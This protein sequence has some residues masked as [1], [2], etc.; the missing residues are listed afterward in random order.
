MSECLFCRILKKEIP[1]KPVFEDDTVYAFS[2]INPQAP[3]HILLIPKKHVAGVEALRSGDEALA[4]N[5]IV[6]ARELASSLGLKAFRLV[7][8]SGPEAGQSVFHLHLHLL[9]G[10]TMTWPP[11]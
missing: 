1:S 6:R 3:T 10:R 9:G 5:L 4:G 8:N 7:F 2:D 11:G